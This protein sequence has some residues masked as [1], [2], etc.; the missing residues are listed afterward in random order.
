[1]AQVCKHGVPVP[2]KFHD[3]D[4][5]DFREKLVPK[6]ERYANEHAGARPSMKPGKRGV[7]PERNAQY[8][9]WAIAWNLLFH[10]FIEKAVADHYSAGDES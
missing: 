2:S 7:Q 4:Y 1:M 9:A 8:E 6:A 3:C 5:A 10:N